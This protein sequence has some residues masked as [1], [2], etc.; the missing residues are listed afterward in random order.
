MWNTN[1]FPARKHHLKM[2]IIVHISVRFGGSRHSSFL[3]P[4]VLPFFIRIYVHIYILYHSPNYF[5]TSSPYHLPSESIHRLPHCWCKPWAPPSSACRS[6][7]WVP[8]W[9]IRVGDPWETHGKSRGNPW[10]I[11]GKS[12]G[13]RW[14]THG[15]TWE[16]SGT[17]WKFDVY[18][19]PL[20]ISGSWWWCW[21][22]LRCMYWD[23]HGGDDS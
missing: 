9:E 7:L 17:C 22:W 8:R 13:N 6:P 11:Q 4:A 5:T 20:R 18:F 16:T 14:E 2:E 19:G 21:C 12:R 23:D 3:S 15:K 10:E 1:L